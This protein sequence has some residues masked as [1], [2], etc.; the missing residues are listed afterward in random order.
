MVSYRQIAV[1]LGICV[2]LVA[3]LSYWAGLDSSSNQLTLQEDAAPIDS[4][5]TLKELDLT[6]PKDTNSMNPVAVLETNK[7]TIEIELFKDTMPVTAGN[8]EKLVSEGYYDG[9]KFHRVIDGFMVQGG[10]PLTKDD[11]KMSMWGTG[12]PGYSIADEHI[13]GEL[14]TNTRGTISMANSGPNSGGSQF[15]INLVDNTNLDFDKPPLTSAHPV[16]GRVIAG[17]DI[18]DAIGKVPTTPG[19][20]RPLEAVVISKASIK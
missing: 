14:L 10:D 7:G 1:L 16:F 5:F 8:F 6:K 19:N 18:V 17:L 3:G 9:I 12:G 4:P 20:N 11:S 2:V 13:V 15:F